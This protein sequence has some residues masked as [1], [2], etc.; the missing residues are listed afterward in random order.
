MDSLLDSLA[1][2]RDKYIQLEGRP[3]KSLARHREILAAI[4]LGDSELASNLMR[5][6]L[7]ETETMLFQ[8]LEKNR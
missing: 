6:H 4:K 7:E 2:S 8:V 5:E 1:E 3:E